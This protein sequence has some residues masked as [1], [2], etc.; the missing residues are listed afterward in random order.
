MD[1]A[2]GLTGSSRGVQH[3][4]IVIRVSLRNFELIRRVFYTF[5]KRRLIDDENM[6]NIRQFFPDCIDPRLQFPGR[7]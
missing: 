4:C 1:D 6:R 7:E 3:E 5:C 2:L